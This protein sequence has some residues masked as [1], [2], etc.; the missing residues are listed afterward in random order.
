MGT[1]YCY[2][3]GKISARPDVKILIHHECKGRFSQ[4]FNLQRLF[5]VFFVQKHL[6]CANTEVLDPYGGL[7]QYVNAVTVVII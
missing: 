7:E 3:T 1:T 5:N 2:G 4:C 6:C